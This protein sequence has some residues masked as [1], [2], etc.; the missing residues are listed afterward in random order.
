MAVLQ[1]HFVCYC[2]RYRR[3]NKVIRLEESTCEKKTGP[4]ALRRLRRTSALERRYLESSDLVR[5]ACLLFWRFA[6]PLEQRAP[7]AGQWFNQVA[8]NPGAGAQLGGVGIGPGGN[9]DGRGSIDDDV[10]AASGLDDRGVVAA[11]ALKLQNF[12]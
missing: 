7:A 6:I 12:L 11:I 1:I 10:G 9:T 4:Q 5:A 8:A 3:L 2:L